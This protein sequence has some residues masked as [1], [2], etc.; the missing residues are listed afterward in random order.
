MLAS[1]MRGPA[2]MRWLMRGRPGKGRRHD[3]PPGRS[4][5][6][7]MCRAMASGRL[8]DNG[9][10]TRPMHAR[11]AGRATIAV[12][13]PRSNTMACFRDPSRPR[14]PGRDDDAWRDA[15]PGRRGCDA[16]DDAD[17]FTRELSDRYGHGQGGYERSAYPQGGYGEAGGEAAM[18]RE[19]RD[20]R[21]DREDR[22][23]S[24]RRS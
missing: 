4:R 7:A 21:E 3:M 10:C 1:D 24:P 16:R 5:G 20:G 9:I 8:T 23:F 18:R 11:H 12:P 17:D 19:R 22:E 13:P 6:S 14:P 2:S 15:E